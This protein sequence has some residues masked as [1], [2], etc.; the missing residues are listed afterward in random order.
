[1]IIKFTYVSQILYFQSESRDE[2]STDSTTLV[3]T[4]PE[5]CSDVTIFLSVHFG[6]WLITAFIVGQC[7][8]LVW[9]F[10]NWHISNLGMFELIAVSSSEFK[11]D[12][13]YIDLLH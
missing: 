8:G 11:F 13:N 7:N 3:Q 1:M 10:L 4:N 9:G 12:S 6:S 2:D 5:P